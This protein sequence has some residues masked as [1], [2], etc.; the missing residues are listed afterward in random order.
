MMDDDKP[1]DCRT[2][3]LRR[4]KTARSEGSARFGGPAELGFPG[5]AAVYIRASRVVLDAT[6][7]ST[8]EL[9]QLA[10]PCIYLQRHA[11]ELII[12]ELHDTAAAITAARSALRTQK[13]YEE[14][15][16]LFGHKLQKLTEVALLAVELE[17]YEVPETVKQLASEL[18]GFEEG[19]ETR[20]RYPEGRAG[21]F[22]RLSFPEQVDA[23]V[24]AWQDVLEQIGA[25][26]LHRGLLFGQHGQ[27]LLENMSDEY[28]QLLQELYAAEFS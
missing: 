4:L 26:V 5:Y 27:T 2:N 17:G 20:V 6:A 28:H 1:N 19:D 7:D 21:D 25:A 10:R 23:P 12:K 9:D 16:P 24:V 3:L 22:T 18:D 13:P 15:K 14:P 11:L 8:K